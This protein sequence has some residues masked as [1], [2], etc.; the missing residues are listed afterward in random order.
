MK[1]M[2]LFVSLM[3]SSSA[4]AGLIDFNTNPDNNYW[5]TPISSNG[6]LFTDITGQGSLG[7]ASNLDNASVDNGTVHLMDWV[8]SG[9]L[10]SVRMEAI[11]N[12][13][14]SLNMFDFTSGYLSGSEIAT[15]LSVSGFDI[16]GNLVASA[17][18]LSNSYSH[19]SFTTLNLS[20][21]FQNLRYVIFDATGS[22]NRVGYDNI[23]VN[24]AVSVPEPSSLVILALGLLGLSRKNKII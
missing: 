16:G 14:F 8:N 1:N 2:V 21:A 9:N 7:T 12:S 20:N 18:F 19:L 23:V 13:L 22:N 11:D 5:D 15:Q 6:F 4:F 17:V 3:L 24:N 10:S